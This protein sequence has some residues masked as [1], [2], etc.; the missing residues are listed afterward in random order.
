MRHHHYLLLFAVWVVVCLLNLGKP[1]LWDIDEGN[2]AEATREMLTSDNYVVP[3]FNYQL[4]VDKPA[5]LYW[6][7]ALAY[8][9]FG[10]NEFSA[11]LPSAIAGLLT[12]LLIYELGRRMYD[13]STGLL[14]ALILGST[15]S[16]CAASHFANPDC[17]LL[18]CSTAS[19]CIF[20]WDY[21]PGRSRWL[22]WSGVTAGLGFLAKG[23]VGLVLPGAIVFLYLLWMRQWRRWFSWH[24]LT[25]I[26]LFVLV[27]VPW[28]AWV[29]AETRGEFLRGFFLKHNLG[30]FQEP[31]ENHRG[32][33][34][35]YIGVVLVG[36]APWS[37]FAPLALWR[38]WNAWRTRKEGD[39]SVD[40]RWR[41]LA[42]WALVFIVFFSCAS[43]KLPNYVL[44]AFPPLALLM[45][46]LLIRWQRGEIKPP[47]WVPSLVVVNLLLVGVGVALG[48]RIAGGSLWP[49][50]IQ[51]HTLPGL[52]HWAFLGVIPVTMA[53]LGTWWLARQQT[54]RWV[55][56]M[57]VAAIAFVAII[58]AGVCPSVN[59]YKPAQ[60]LAK[61]I[62]VDAIEGDVTVGTYH[63]FQPSLVFYCRC[64]VV[65]WQQ[66]QHAL[67]SLRYPMPVYLIVPAP[68]WEQM[69]VRARV[70]WREVAR[71][72]DLYR[73]HDVVLISNR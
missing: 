60:K 37:V 21:E 50:V 45:G 44:P 7:Q 32:P 6:C 67:D 5:L 70:P 28:Y 51:G 19:L 3:T 22:M 61:H 18:M 55:T 12:L 39:R 53:T 15:L 33:I 58:G 4:R 65:P 71:E 13:A 31:M 35:Y 17:L 59:E 20:W 27:A 41:F 23:P 62:N 54:H 29:G 47:V 24:L 43:T 69:K 56:S 11:R 38:L 48:L 9:T 14:T 68:I 34:F 16:F 64:E 73:R 52:E 25:G 40:P 26:L 2:N 36:G 46:R 63:W 72:R 42:C 1:T 8:H 66:E 30:R 10:V 49:E 57:A